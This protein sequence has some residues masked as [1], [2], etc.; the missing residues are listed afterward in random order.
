MASLINP[1]L[2][3]KTGKEIVAELT[4]EAVQPSA[5]QINAP[6]SDATGKAILEAIKQGGGGGGDGGDGPLVI[7][8]SIDD[9]YTGEGI[10]YVLDVTTEE[11]LAA[12]NA[13]KII[14]YAKKGV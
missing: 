8:E 4:G 10:K 1:P 9:N 7:H 12:V 11:L 3:D 13:G 5:S 2:L 14:V 6:I